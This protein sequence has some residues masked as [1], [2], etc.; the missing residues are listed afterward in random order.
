MDND[1][2]PEI[3]RFDPNKPCPL[4]TH[5]FV[6]IIRNDRPIGILCTACG[7][8]VKEDRSRSGWSVASNGQ[9]GFDEKTA[10][11]FD[12]IKGK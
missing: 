5:E 3:V 7:K 4:A 9:V 11:G 12:K 6:P 10:S 2:D 1:R 8:V